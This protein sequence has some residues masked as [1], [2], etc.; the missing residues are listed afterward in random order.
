MNSGMQR[1]LNYAKP[2]DVDLDLVQTEFNLNYF[3]YLALTKAF[4]PFLMDRDSESG[5]IL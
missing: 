3:S 5:L 2:N 1:G 4:L